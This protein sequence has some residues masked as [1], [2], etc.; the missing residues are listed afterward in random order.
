MNPQGKPAGS[1]DDVLKTAASKAGRFF[2][3]LREEYKAGLAGEPG[4]SQSSLPPTA[5]PSNARPWWQVL[6]VPE[7][8]SL[9]EITAAYRDLLHK[10]HPDKV[11]QLSDRLRQVAAEET[12]QLNAAYEE[13]RRVKARR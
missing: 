4:P 10:S 11:A 13:A 12:Q 5:R 6:G 1:S 9:Q 7:T 3:R 8:A 2:R